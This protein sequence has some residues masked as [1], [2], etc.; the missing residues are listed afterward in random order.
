MLQRALGALRRTARIASEPPRASLWTVIV[1]GCAATALALVAVAIANVS[2]W[3]DDARGEGR[4]AGMVVYLAD[5]AAPARAEAIVGQLRAIAGVE[6]AE[7]VGSAETARRLELALGRGSD[8]RALLAGVDTQGLPASIEVAFAPGVRDVVALSPTIKTLRGAPGVADVVV[9]EDREPGR[10]AAGT[11]ATVRAVVWSG[12]GVLGALALIVVLATI[13]VRLDRD[14]RGRREVAV[15]E[16]LGA[17]PGFFAIPTA[18]AG[19]CYAALGAGIGVGAVALGAWRYG[20][21][22][23]ARLAPTLGPVE[24]ALPGALEIAIFVGGLAFLGLLG[25]GLAS[26]TARSGERAGAWRVARAGA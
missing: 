24:V 25:G 6:R 23:A 9:S 26:T 13:R 10:V 17:H 21:D 5:D 7:L 2:R 4:G 20:D 16:L 3:S 12:G 14:A 1:L 19:L 8:D 18:L 22:V 15:A 11:L